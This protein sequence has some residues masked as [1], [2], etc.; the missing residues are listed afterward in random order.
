MNARQIEIF[1]AVMKAG[2][3]TEAAKQLGI[4]QP[5]ATATLRQVEDALGFNLFHRVG[6]RLAPTAEARALYGEAERI[7]GSL[8][9]FRNLAAR[10]KHDLTSHLRVVAPPAFCHE[11]LP[12]AV[13]DMMRK[14]KNCVLDMTTLHHKQILTDITT[15]GG[16]NNLGFT[17]GASDTEGVG[18]I[19]IGK[20]HIVAL[21]P[22]AW[23]LAHKNSVTITEL[24]N[25]PLIGTFAGEPLGD[26]V[27][28]M[29][30]KAKLSHN[31]AIRAHSHSV[32]A[33]LAGQAV[34]TAMIDSITA[35]YTK[36][37]LVN[38]GFKILAVEQ[39][40]T[41]PVTAIFSYEH[42]LT[43]HAKKLIECFRKRYRTLVTDED[44]PQ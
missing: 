4:T 19:P 18:S 27:E 44:T 23:P 42:P 33:S 30:R 13:A 1:Y 24:A 32:A 35:A 22:E 28:K 25:T 10:L 15:T 40:P 26:A 5:S 43:P 3:V 36:A 14:N 31:P 20:A 11:L 39:A 41:L 8:T 17:F 38:S 7:Q 37:R 34:G 9:V 6:G 16:Q 12:S 29:M 2:T 21:V